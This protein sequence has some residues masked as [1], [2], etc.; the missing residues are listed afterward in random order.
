MLNNLAWSAL[1]TFDESLLEDA[2]R[3]SAAAAELLPVEPAISS[4]RGTTLVMMGRAEE[5]MP[6][7]ARAYRTASSHGYHL[8]LVSGFG[9]IGAAGVGDHLLMRQR[10]GDMITQDPRCPIRREVEQ[11]LGPSELVRFAS[12]VIDEDGDLDVA[13]FTDEERAALPATATLA[14]A[15]LNG[16]VGGHR[17]DDDDRIDADASKVG[18]QPRGVRVQAI[19][20]AARHVLVEHALESWTPINRPAP[21][22]DAWLQLCSI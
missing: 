3:W 11:R 2:D 7:L 22:M 21:G 14:L 5:G 16:D 18:D 13:A 19:R 17:Y 4:T 15:L 12:L 8:A 1:M 9:A 20:A 10:Y 6:L